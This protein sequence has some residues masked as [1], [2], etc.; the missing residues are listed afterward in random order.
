MDENPA[1]YRKGERVYRIDDRKRLLEDVAQIARGAG[2]QVME[3]YA[4]TIE[5]L[6]KRDAS[7]VTLADERAEAFITPRLQALSP[8]VAV[9]AEEAVAAGGVSQVGA[10]FWLVDPLD[11]TREFISRN[12]EFT[13]NIALVEHGQP[14]LGVVYAPAL[15]L[16][17]A[18]GPGLGSWMEQG[19]QR[20]AIRCRRAPAEGLRVVASRSHGDDTALEAFL[21]GR[22]VAASVSVGSS[23][24]L[25]LVAQGEADVY[26]RLGRTMEWDIAAGHAVVAGAGGAVE[27]LDG[28]ALTYGKPGFDNPH[29]AAWGLRTASLAAATTCL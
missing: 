14:V 12:G 13:V 24:K 26:P 27:R 5:V 15:D 20:R 22:S 17:C 9:V 8:D 25:C 2:A 6:H 7:P 16:L 23:L 28:G 21:A 18:G 19:G 1:G 29:F 4:G 3:I 11:G 10:A